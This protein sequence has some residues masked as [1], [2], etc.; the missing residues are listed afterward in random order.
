MGSYNSLYNKTGGGG[1]LDDWRII[2]DL[3]CRN[4][5]QSTFSALVAFVWVFM[6]MEP[7]SSDSE[8]LQKKIF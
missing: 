2:E 5:K 7:E 8:D 4:P 1:F 3:D 6:W